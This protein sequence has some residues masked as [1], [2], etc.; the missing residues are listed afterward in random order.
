MRRLPF[1]LPAFI[2]LLLAAAPAGAQPVGSESEEAVVVINGDVAVE[3]GEVVE[4]VF[5]VNGDARIGGRVDG[6]VLLVAG[7]AL[8]SGRIDG[9]LVTL[10]GRAR[11]LPNAGVGGD[12]K[13]GDK[14]PRVAPGATVEG[15]IDKEDWA[16][17]G[18]LGFI[19]AFVFWLA[20][21]VSMAVLGILLLLISPRAADAIFVQAQSRFWTAVGIGALIF[22]VI[23]VAIFVASITLLGLPLGIALGLAA[24]PLAAVAYVTAAWALGRTIVKPPRDRILSFLAGLAILR[25][26]ALVP[27]LGVLVWLAAVIV[28]LGLLGAAVTAAREP[29]AARAPG[30]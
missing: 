11:L 27:V 8:V 5:I 10:A 28:G 30:S 29:A 24:L 16:D 20:M 4:G 9:N 15:D 17:L 6:D 18:L 12:L 19:G 13:Y 25:L 22:I 21:T 2:A 14:E 23:P 7:D 26:A 1:L 3:R